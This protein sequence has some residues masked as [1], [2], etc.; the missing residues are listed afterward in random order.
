MAFPI[1]PGKDEHGSKLGNEDG[2]M[3]DGEVSRSGS[4]RGGRSMS[5]REALETAGGS[6]GGAPAGL[7]QLSD[8]KRG[9]TVEDGSFFARAGGFAVEDGRGF[10]VRIAEEGAAFVN[11]ER[12]QLLRFVD[13]GF[14]LGGCQARARGVH[15]WMSARSRTMSSRG[16]ESDIEELFLRL[17]TEIGVLVKE[18][19]K[20]RRLLN[21]QLRYKSV[22]T[23]VK[24]L[25]GALKTGG[26]KSKKSKKTNKKTCYSCGKHGHLQA[27]CLKQKKVKKC[28]LCSETGH[29]AKACTVSKKEE[30]DDV[31]QATA[32]VHDQADDDTTQAGEVLAVEGTSEEQRRSSPL[33]TKPAVDRGRTPPV[34]TA[35][36][37][38]TELAGRSRALVR[39]PGRTG[40]ARAA[41]R[42]ARE[43]RRG[44][45][46]GRARSRF[47]A[48]AMAH[49]AVV[50][51]I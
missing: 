44:A 33:P 4:V 47:K 41:C 43:A 16:S 28:W 36:R 19:E 9:G 32:S 11:D 45:E 25:R 40:G 29:L 1:F 17:E 27:R 14:V 37:P 12:K 13:G 18:R 2:S 49:G 20:L 5:L 34:A 38:A 24:E 35:T 48:G 30:A 6:N 51:C 3:R 7:R 39:T 22:N 46:R 31:S 50:Q 10:P 8:S 26:H 15:G 23:E 21:L 42:V